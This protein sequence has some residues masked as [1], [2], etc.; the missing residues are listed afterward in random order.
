MESS[1][2]LLEMPARERGELHFREA[3]GVSCQV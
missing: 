1:A 2:F 3:L